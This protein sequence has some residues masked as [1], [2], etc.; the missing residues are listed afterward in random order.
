MKTKSFWQSGASATLR[1]VGDKVYWA[2][3]TIVVQD[4]PDLI[5]L[6]MPAGVLG[7]DTDHKPTTKELLSLDEIKI[8]DYQWKR[9]DVLMLIVPG[10][11]FSTYIMWEAGT[12]NLDCW[13]VNLQEPI[14]RTSIGFDTM[15]NMLDVV[16][17]PDMSE[18]HWKDDDEF[19][20]A[21][22]IGFY[23]AE[24]AH[25]IWAEGER[26]VQLITKE[27]RDLYKKWE[28]WQANPEWELPIL[29][30]DWQK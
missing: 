13:Y 12:K 4:S 2:F 29:S 5:V 19:A 24:K 27:R 3:P 30:P 16:I 6:Y 25:E 28:M 10:E 11:A 26:A 21:Q 17:S 18:W 9:T 1:G 15:D 7:K 8:A 14:R 22:K 23:S 20:A